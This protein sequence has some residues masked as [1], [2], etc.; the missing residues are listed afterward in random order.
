MLRQAV[1]CQYKALKARP[2]DEGY[3]HALHNELVAL[4][5]ACLESGDLAGGIGA[6]TEL[7]ELTPIKSVNCEDAAAFFARAYGTISTA[8]GLTE[9]QRK[10]A[11][12]KCGSSAVALI[13][14]ASLLGSQS[15]RL[16]KTDERFAV[17]RSY[18]PFMAM[19]EA[20]P[21]PVDHGPARFEI[22]YTFDDPG[23]RHWTHEGNMWMEVQ[24]SGA[25]NVFD[26]D[27]RG[28]I[29]GISGTVIRPRNSSDLRIFVPDLGTAKPMRMMLSLKPGTWRQFA[30][31]QNE[32]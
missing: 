2:L 23:I 13:G 32:E 28:V 29:S 18:A 14:T 7:S 20:E 1:E 5:D 9:E 27:R 3:T 19:S 21:D 22:D 25:T 8:A 16:A 11:M 26:T 30:T 24:P 6:A 31:V 17:L 15:M 4:A 10:G 12:E